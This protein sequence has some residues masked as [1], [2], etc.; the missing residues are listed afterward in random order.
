MRLCFGSVK[1]YVFSDNYNIP[2]AAGYW[3]LDQA[4]KLT[5]GDF[6]MSEE[7]FENVPVNVRKQAEKADAM[8]KQMQGEAPSKENPPVNSQETLSEPPANEPEQGTPPQGPPQD[9]FEH[10][11][12]V[13]QGKYNAEIPRF[14]QQISELY[15]EL[16]RVR[17]ERDQQ[18]QQGPQQPEATSVEGVDPDD[19]S[20]YGEEFGKLAKSFN[21]LLEQNKTLQSKLSSIE[22]STQQVQQDQVSNK[23]EQFWGKL[24]Q[25]VPNWEEINQNQDFLNWL[26]QEDPVSGTQ[27]QQILEHHHKAMDANRVAGVFKAWMQESGQGQKQS[28][29]KAEPKNV[30]PEQTRADQPSQQTQTGRTWTKAQ[31]KKHYDDQIKGL[32]N[33]REDEWKKIEREIHQAVQ[34]GRVQ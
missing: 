17:A 10:K 29:S 32:W 6:N 25:Q 4:Y 9:S 20:E 33:S 7:N 8:M 1:T 22:N 28:P 13:L 21:A 12:K 3:L 26:T 5:Y 34:E 27:R 30:Q 15:S 19:L 23:E 2:P 31:I 16:S 14:Q 24:S 18:Q 11:Y